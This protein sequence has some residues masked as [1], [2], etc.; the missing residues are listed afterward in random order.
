MLGLD[1]QA[2][3]GQ[4]NPLTR[5]FLPN[6]PQVKLRGRSQMHTCEQAGSL[7]GSLEKPPIDFPGNRI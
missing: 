5:V 4:S 6:P 2:Q 1:S 3:G 7:E